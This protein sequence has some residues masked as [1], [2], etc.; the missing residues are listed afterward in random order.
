MYIDLRTWLS[1][2]SLSSFRWKESF[3]KSYTRHIV[4]AAAATGWYSW[5]LSTVAAQFWQV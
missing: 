2:L 3:R 4:G 1:F 5:N